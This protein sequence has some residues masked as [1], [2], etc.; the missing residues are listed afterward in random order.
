[1]KNCF[2]FVAGAFVV[3]FT[4]GAFAQE[5]PASLLEGKKATAG[6][7]DVATSG[8][9]K[10][11]I[12]K[13][14]A[15][16]LEL[17]ISAGGLSSGGNAS[18]LALTANSKFRYK[19]E[20][21]QLSA[22]VVGNYGRARPVGAATTETT[23]ENVQGKVR[24]DRFLSERLALFLATSAL[25]NRFQGLVLRLNIDPGIAYYFVQE[26]KQRFWSEFGYDFQYDVRRDDALA[27]AV[28]A[29]TPVD[30]TEVN[31]N[32]RLFLGYENSLT[33][34]FA[35]D[36]GA[37]FLQSVSD[38]DNR[39]LNVDAGFTSAVAGNLSIAATLN[40]RY[41]DNPLPGVRKTDYTT[42]LSLV[43]QLL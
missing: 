7:E 37:E 6:S 42:A 15:E 9:E 30:K 33:E 24:Y 39:W 1:M 22:A 12:P 32:G 13:D 38:T 5:E 20:Q 11:E 4:S 29:G 27:A 26:E 34:T 2:A 28:L 10:A 35:F 23:V 25:T 18:A 17:K 21:N 14:D 31:H 16:Q 36:A 19:R 41:D 8:F 3:S 40:L 43:Y